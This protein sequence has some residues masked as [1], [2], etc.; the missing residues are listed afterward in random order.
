MKVVLN[1]VLQLRNQ[2]N[3]SQCKHF[4]CSYIITSYEQVVLPFYLFSLVGK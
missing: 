1:E 4:A 3:I 2:I